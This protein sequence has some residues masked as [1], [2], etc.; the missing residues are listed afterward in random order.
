MS[1]THYH[2]RRSVPIF[3][4]EFRLRELI[5]FIGAVTTGAIGG[6]VA[7]FQHAR[8]R[9]ETVVAYAV[10]YAVTGAFGALMAL[11]GI[12]AFYPGAINGWPSLLLVS[13]LSGVIVSAAL[14]AGNLSM[15]FVL[16]KLGLEVVV[17]VKKAEKSGAEQ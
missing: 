5:P 12:M 7:C 13:G 1:P 6:C 11:A 9:R 15:R 8:T 14:A 2:L 17:S 3:D 10:A 4:G 16:A